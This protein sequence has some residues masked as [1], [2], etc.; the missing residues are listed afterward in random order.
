[1]NFKGESRMA[2]LILESRSLRRLSRDR[3]GLRSAL[4]LAIIAFSSIAGPCLSPY[5]ESAQTL[6]AAFEHPTSSHAF[7]RDALGRDLLTRTLYGGRVSL[8]VGLAGAAIAL[9][10]G[11][12][13]G[14]LAGMLG[15][16]GERLI[17][18]GIDVLYA[19][20]LLLVV[21]ALMVVLGQGLSNVFIALGLVYWLGMARIVRARVAELRR[22]E[23]V[24]AAHALGQRPLVIFLRHILPN[25]S[26]VI[27]VTATFMIPEAIF[28][29]SFLSF[30]GLGITLPHASWGTLAAEGL[31]AMRSHPHV[32]AFPATAICVTIFAF[33]SFGEAMRRA[34]DP[35]EAEMD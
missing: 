2:A 20:P 28:V 16:R 10:I 33:Q 21:I 23:F 15:G 29:E 31:T 7:G 9:V 30:L 22:L 8:A 14:G 13:V 34:L 3:L 35:R 6:T 27:L 4:A 11:V 17:L 32:L 5:E 19:V 26:G 1:M 25:A 24:H 12:A 18:R